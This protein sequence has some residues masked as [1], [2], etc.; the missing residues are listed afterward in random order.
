MNFIFSCMIRYVNKHE[1]SQPETR[2]LVC[3]SKSGVQRKLK[4]K[5]K[6]KLKKCF[7]KYKF[8]VDEDTR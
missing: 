3:R 2:P 1:P 4:L 8:A 5:I 7:L 6:V